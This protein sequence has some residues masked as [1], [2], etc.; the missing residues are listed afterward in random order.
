MTIILFCVSLIL[1]AAQERDAPKPK[2]ATGSLS[3]RI[4]A[5]ETGKPI[6][7]A[8]VTISAPELSPNRAVSTDADGR[9]SFVTLPAGRYTISV[10]KPGYLSLTYGQRRPYETGTPVTVS[11]GQALAKLDIALPRAAAIS[12]NVVDEF[13]EPMARVRVAAQRFGYVRGQRR[14]T[15]TGDAATTDDLG[16]FR[17][18]G[19]PPGDYYV[20]ASPPSGSFAQLTED[21]SGYTRTFFPSALSEAQATR[22]TLAVGQ[23]VADIVIALPPARL[24]RISGTAV[25]S[26]GKAARWGTGNLRPQ[27]ARWGDSGWS[28]MFQ[29]GRWTATG[30]PAGTYQLFLQTMEDPQRVAQT[31]STIGMRVEFAEQDLTVTGENIE[32]V[33]VVTAPAGTATGRVL[34]EGGMTFERMKDHAYL[35]ALDA[36]GIAPAGGGPVLP[37]GTFQLTGLSGHRVFRVEAPPRAEWIMKSVTLNGTDITDTP[38]LTPLGAQLSGLEVTITTRGAQ[39]TGTAQSSKGAPTSD[40]TVVLFAADPT[41]RGPYSRFTK[42]ARPDAN[43]RFTIDSLPSGEYLAVA[44]EYVEPGQ[45]MDPEFLE[46]LARS[47]AT[48]TL[49]EG[50]KKTLMLKLPAQ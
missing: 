10:A 7:R 21:R 50:E 47:A 35:R 31:G 24:A 48:V 4:T 6:R 49:A 16:A 20:S 19:L 26:T 14:L 44:L 29:E 2:P 32:G 45:E 30:V 8:Q 22:L 9:W 17:I 13:G 38:I 40:Y 33:T 46:R 41:R 34:F 28:F 25:D 3:G 37:G 12:G 15:A 42:T 18:Y 43:G 39:L 23:T 27:G 1:G 11:E 5:L 36:D